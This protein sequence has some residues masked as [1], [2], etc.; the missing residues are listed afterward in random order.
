MEFISPIGKFEPLFD[1]LWTTLASEQEQR[2]WSG[3]VSFRN[4]NGVIY[5][6]EGYK[7]ILAKENAEILAAAD[8][9][10]Y[11]DTC[12]A[13]TECFWNAD[14]L[15]SLSSKENAAMA[16]SKAP[17]PA[18]NVIS[19]VLTCQ[20]EDEGMAFNDAARFFGNRFDVVSY[21]FFLKD[22]ERFFSIR[23]DTYGKRLAMLGYRSSCTSKCSWENYRYFLFALRD[24]RQNL[25]EMLPD[26]EYV[27]L[28]DAESFMWMLYKLFD[29]HGNLKPAKR[30][31]IRPEDPLENYVIGMEG[32]RNGY[33]VTRYERDPRLRNLAAARDDYTCQVCGIRFDRMYGPIGHN[34]IEV[35]HTVPLHTY[36]EERQ[37]DPS[38]LVSVCPNCH[39]M[40]HRKKNCVLSIQELQTVIQRF[41][42]KTT[43]HTT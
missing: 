39:R 8:R 43:S 18:W 29:S 2:G 38:E 25:T 24:I 10:D 35:H 26:E 23:S 41:C 31:I 7:E 36:N 20:A 42:Q 5:R 3:P 40:L 37:T 33:Y 15:L 16:I 21:L 9:Y 32:S 1:Q 11:A 27:R 12:R 14:N 6:Q 17:S 19:Q 13:V 4:T 34:Y 22:P 28:I 30:K